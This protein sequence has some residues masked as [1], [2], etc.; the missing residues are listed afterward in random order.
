MNTEARDS[1]VASVFQSNSVKFVLYK[2]A[3]KERI[4]NIILN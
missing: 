2:S 4:I 3:Q 1:E